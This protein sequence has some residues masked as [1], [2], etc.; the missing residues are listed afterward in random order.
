MES[1]ALSIYS[2]KLSANSG[3]LTFPLQFWFLLF[4]FFFVWLLW[5]RLPVQW[6]VK[7][8]RVGKSVLF[9]IPRGKA[10]SFSPLS[11]MLS[12]E[13]AILPCGSA[14][15]ESTCNVW[16]LGSIPGLARFPG[17]G[18]IYPLQ[19]SGLKNSMDCIVHGVTKSQ[20]WLSKFQLP[21]MVFIMLWYIPSKPTMLS[22]YHNQMLDFVKY[23]LCIY[24]DDNM[25][26]HP[27]S[28]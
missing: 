23:S 10:F 22:L 7:V 15:I 13:F 25:I 6:W 24:W 16:D 5:L 18:N 9:L 1:L 12:N 8:V 3:N 26:F 2:I 27:L 19:Y 20:T 14:A 11:M 4:F 17:E 28:C 21:F